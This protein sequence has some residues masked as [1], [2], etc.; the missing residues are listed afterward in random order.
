MVLFRKGEGDDSS[1]PKSKGT[2]L[3]SEDLRD[4]A[5]L[6][7]FIKIHIISPSCPGTL[8]I[9]YCKEKGLT[10]RMFYFT[11][12]LWGLSKLLDNQVIGHCN[13][14]K[15]PKN[16]KGRYGVETFTI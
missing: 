6:A 9:S 10:Y 12:P 16:C 3:E 15:C 5:A 7:S 11:C 14:D 8:Q 2:R 4:D 1:D 13:T